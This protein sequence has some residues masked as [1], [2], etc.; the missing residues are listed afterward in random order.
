M[1]RRGS[2]NTHIYVVICDFCQLKSLDNTFDVIAVSEF[3]TSLVITLLFILC[4][5]HCQKNKK[6]E[7]VNCY[8]KQELT[9]KWIVD[10][11]C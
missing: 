10:D 9:S 8:V 3:W 1:L 7:G 5:P 6:G 4:L 11:G 2:T